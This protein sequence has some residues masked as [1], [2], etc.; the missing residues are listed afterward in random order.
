MLTLPLTT[1]DQAARMEPLFLIGGKVAYD[2]VE[3]AETDLEIDHGIISAM[4]TSRSKPEPNSRE[5]SFN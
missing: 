2:A 1:R 5:V 4:N 3:V